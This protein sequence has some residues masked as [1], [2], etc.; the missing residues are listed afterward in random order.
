M[1]PSCDYAVSGPSD[2]MVSV[3]RITG[4]YVTNARFGLSKGGLELG[5]FVK[6]V[7]NDITDQGVNVVEG[8]VPFTIT[9]RPRTIGVEATWR[10]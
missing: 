10:F 7:F 4:P 1:S 3:G 5:F 9:T 6:N 2:V 8:D